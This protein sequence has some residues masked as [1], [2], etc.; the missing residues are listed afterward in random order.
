MRVKIAD[1]RAWQLTGTLEHPGEFWEGR[2]V[3][4]TD[5]YEPYRQGGPRVLPKKSEGQYTIESTFLEIVSDDGI[6]GRAGP[7][8]AQQALN[9]QQQFGALLKDEDPMAI[10]R[11]WDL[12]H[13]SA[14]HGRKGTTMMAISAIDCALWDLKGIA[15]GLPAYRLLGGPTRE[16]IPAYASTLGFS[17]EDLE[18]VAKRASDFAAAGYKAQKWFFRRGPA[19]GR[20]GMAENELMVRTVREAAGEDS[21][22]MFDAWMSWDPEYAVAMAKRIEQYRVRWIEEPVLPDKIASHAAIRARSPVPI[23]T[24]EHE[25]TRWGIQLL[26]DAQ[27]ADV[28]QPDT[29]WAG[30]LTEMTKICTL[31]SVADLPVIPHGH[32][33]SANVQLLASQPPNVCPLAEDLIKWNQINEFFLKDPIR[34]E[35]GHLLLPNTPGVGMEIDEEKIEHTE[36]IG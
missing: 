26:I 30:G 18:L 34:R 23:S 25:Y 9:I 5:L 22:L 28:L 21:D 6:V 33:V 12:M 29:Y 36:A 13:R 31:A 27:A 1:V 2:L 15:L 8:S 35:N 14:V 20:E 17:I 32:S 3:R 4:P 11:I 16:V 19:D 24:G 10:E 7:I